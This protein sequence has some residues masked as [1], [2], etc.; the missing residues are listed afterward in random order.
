M[1][2]TVFLF[3]LC[4]L[5]WFVLL[6]DAYEEPFSVMQRCAVVQCR[7]KGL[8]TS[9]GPKGCL[10]RALGGGGREA[11]TVLLR[12]NNLGSAR[13]SRWN[14]EFWCPEPPGRRVAAPKSDFR[15]FFCVRSPLENWGPESYFVAS[16]ETAL[17]YLVF[18]ALLVTM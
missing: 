17:K 4:P 7:E 10:R 5:V 14:H 9:T 18:V 16:Y 12:G 15:S 2:Q 6:I 11:E 1:Y 3:L 13:V 8:A